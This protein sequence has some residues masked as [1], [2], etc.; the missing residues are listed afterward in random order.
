MRALQIKGLHQKL[1]KADA[2]MMAMRSKFVEHALVHTDTLAELM[3]LKIS[4]GRVIGELRDALETL[5]MASETAGSSEVHF[6]MFILFSYDQFRF[7]KQQ[8]SLNLLLVTV[9]QACIR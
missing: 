3:D 6:C 2:D 5:R 9:Y 7:H 8:E 4:H 1:V